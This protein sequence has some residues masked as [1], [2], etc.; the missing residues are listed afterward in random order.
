MFVRQKKNKSGIVSVQIIDKSLGKYRML[1]S[2]SSSADSEEVLRL[3]EKG[4]H[5][6]K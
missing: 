1:K 6:I 3:V 5:W 2:I 4:N